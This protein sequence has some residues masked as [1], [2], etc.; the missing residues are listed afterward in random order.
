MNSALPT[1][2]RAVFAFL[3]E[4]LPA[5][6]REAFRMTEVNLSHLNHMCWEEETQFAR[7]AR[8]LIRHS[9]SLHTTCGALGEMLKQYRLYHESY[10]SRAL[11][12]AYS[13]HMRGKD[14]LEALT[15]DYDFNMDA[16]VSW[17]TKEQEQRAVNAD[18][19]GED[20]RGLRAD[21]RWARCRTSGRIG[22]MVFRG[23][24]LIRASIECYMNIMGPN[25]SWHEMKERYDA[26]GGVKA[27]LAG[28]FD[29]PPIYFF[30]E[31]TDDV[32]ASPDS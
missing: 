9:F 26:L 13:L 15:A 4:A 20:R 30:D 6:A 17:L 19:F 32:N 14:P 11:V 3:D 5:E 22:T 31:Q 8:F 1:G 7:D 23:D 2:L 27:Y 10:S 12:W 29:W 28:K 16:V 21:D 18:L 24:R 25:R